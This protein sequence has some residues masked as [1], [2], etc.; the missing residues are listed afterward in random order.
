ML[1]HIDVKTAEQYSDAEV[2]HRWHTLFRGTLLTHKFISANH[3]LSDIEKESV[4]ATVAVWRQRLTSVSWFMKSLNEYIAKKANKEDDCTGHFW[5]GRFKSQAILDETA[6]LA[7][8]LYIDL[9]PV[10]AGLAN[11]PESSDFTSLNYRLKNNYAKCTNN[12]YNIFNTTGNAN[13]L[14]SVTFEQYVLLIDEAAR[15]IIK[16]KSAIKTDLLPIM[17]RLQVESA[18]FLNASSSFETSFSQI[19]G[20]V[21][22]MQQYAHK[23]NRRQIKGTFC[24]TN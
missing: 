2:I 6:L 20:N 18:Q 4:K 8:M 21:H 5:E 14:V 12:I 9:N 7:C 24:L 15:Y 3:D 1:L 19:A 13:N 10:R 11:T 23:H 22:S 16:G 17:D